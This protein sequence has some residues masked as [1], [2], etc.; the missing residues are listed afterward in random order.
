MSIDASPT[1]QLDADDVEAIVARA[2]ADNESDRGG[3]P[4]D[5][6]PALIDSE[7]RRETRIAPPSVRASRLPSPLVE[8]AENG[9]E[10]PMTVAGAAKT[11]LKVQRT[12]WQR[13][14]LTSTYDRAIGTYAGILDTD[15][16]LRDA[17]NGLTTALVTRRLSPLDDSGEWLEPL[18]IERQLHDEAARRSFTRAIRYQLRDYD[19]QYVGVTAAT[20]TAATPHEHVLIWIDDPDDVVGVEHFR[21]AI[22]KHVEKVH[23]AY[24]EDHPIQADG[25]GGA[26]TIYHDPPLVD[27]VP[28]AIDEAFDRVRKHSDAVD[29]DATAIPANTAGAQYVASQ[30][31]HLVVGD[32]YDGTRDVD[33]VRIDGGAIAWASTHNWIRS[34]QDVSVN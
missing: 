31:P 19:Y 20:T 32:V 15:R 28:D 13:D 24:D 6:L 30:L 9:E 26:V 17:Y 14:D 12:V 25:R 34:S 27:H 8:E 29:D 21:P 10:R 1:D 18:A 4:A 22:E 33:D 16:Q 5:P 2:F 3:E 23:N 11:Y 7:R